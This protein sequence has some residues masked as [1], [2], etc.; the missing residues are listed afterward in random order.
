MRDADGEQGGRGPDQS[1]APGIAGALDPKLGS[2]HLDDDSL[3]LYESVFGVD[4]TMERIEKI[5]AE[6]SI[7][8]F[9]RIDHGKNAREAG[10]EMPPSKV[11]IFGSPK[12]GTNLMLENPGI[13]TELPLRIAVWED[14]EGSTWISFPHMEKI[15]RAYGVEN[16]PPV[17]P[18]RQLLR[19]IVSRA[20]NV[21]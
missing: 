11:V 8:V 4:E 21:Y 7:P 1:G 9:A 15:A 17:A 5:L 20:A 2:G 16:L 6:K 3:Y 12:V 14:K 10:L 19:N 18:I 13:A